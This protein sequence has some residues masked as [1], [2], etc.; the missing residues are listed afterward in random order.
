MWYEKVIVKTGFGFRLIMT[1]INVVMT[2]TISFKMMISP[3]ISI[4]I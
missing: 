2:V 3:I 4:I 1:T